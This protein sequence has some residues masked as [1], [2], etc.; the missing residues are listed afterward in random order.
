VYRK[1]QVR[2]RSQ[3]TGKGWD[4]GP[5]RTHDRFCHKFASIH[6]GTASSKANCDF[7]LIPII[8]KTLVNNLMVI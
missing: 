5:V 4:L 2:E 7:K 6:E 1:S 3:Y 8:K